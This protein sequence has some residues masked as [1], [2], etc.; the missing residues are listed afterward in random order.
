MLGRRRT[1]CGVSGRVGEEG[2][3]EGGKGW[4]G[5]GKEVL[6]RVKSYWG[7]R[8]SIGEGEEYLGRGESVEGM[9]GG[10]VYN[11]KLEEQISKSEKCPCWESEAEALQHF[12]SY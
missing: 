6:G 4:V 1:C 7:G 3:I 2:W 11:I 12:L 8:G 9:R 10:T 5:E